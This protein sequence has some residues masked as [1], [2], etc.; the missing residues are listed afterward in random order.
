MTT[1]SE[2]VDAAPET[3]SAVLS[4]ALTCIATSNPDR[5]AVES[6]GGDLSYAEL[7]TRVRTMARGLASVGVGPGT[8]VG[9]YMRRSPA[10]LVALAGVAHSG[11]AY[12]PLDPAYPA[13][14]LAFMMEQAGASL[15]LVDAEGG[16]RL[17]PTA[18][19]LTVD[20]YGGADF[21]VFPS[22]A[23][24][25]TDTAYI[26]YTSGSSGQ[27]KGITTTSANFL[28]FA[29]GFIAT[30]GLNRDDVFLASTSISFDPHTVEI[31]LPILLGARIILLGDGEAR[32]PDV[33]ER[34][35]G[36][37][38]VTVVQGTP[39]FW[40]MMMDSGCRGLSGVT[41]LCGGEPLT[42]SLQDRLFDAGLT[43]LWNIYG[44]TETTV[45]CSAA[46]MV[47]GEQPTVGGPLPDTVFHLLDDTF[48]EIEVGEVGEL[49]IGG[50][51]LMAGYVN[52]PDLTAE[53]ILHAAP[54]GINDRLYRS[55]DMFEKR[56]G[57][58]LRYVGR[59]DSQVKLR[60]YRI[61]LLEIE[62]MLENH[63]QIGRAA[64]VVDPINKRL[65]AYIQLRGA[66]SLGSDEAA[67]FLREQLP[68]F[69]VPDR[70]E[71]VQRFPQTPSG[72]VDRIELA[73]RA[74]EAAQR[75]PIGGTGSSWDRISFIWSDV[76]GAEQI[77]P[78]TDF[79]EAG[80]NSVNMA[81]LRMR[82]QESFGVR[83]T[84]EQIHANRRIADMLRLIEAAPP[85]ASPASKTTLVGE[86][87]LSPSQLLLIEELGPDEIARDNLEILL[88]VD[89]GVD[90]T[91]QVVRRLCTAHDIFS[92]RSIDLRTRKQSFSRS[93]AYRI[94]AHE[95][96]FASLEEFLRLVP[97]LRE[98][99]GWSRPDLYR[100]E[101]FRTPTDSFVF[102]AGSH[103]LFD[104]ASLTLMMEN[105]DAM[106]RD[107]DYI[108]YD[109]HYSQWLQEASTLCPREA[110]P[111]AISFDALGTWPSFAETIAL[112]HRVVAAG[113]TVNRKHLPGRT[114]ALR[115]L[116]LAA[117]CLAVA[118]Q[119]ALGTI[120]CR[121]ASSGRGLL[122]GVDDLGTIGWLSHHFPL[123]VACKGELE[124]IASI[125]SHSLDTLAR[126]G[127]DY[128]WARYAARQPELMARPDLRHFP[129]YF[130]FLPD[131]GSKLAHI[132]DITD[133]LP[134]VSEPRDR[135]C[136]IGFVV[137]DGAELSIAAYYDQATL[138]TETVGRV[139]AAIS[140]LLTRHTPVADCA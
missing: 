69:M 71:I 96:T 99:V 51:G 135:L 44:P 30:L 120:P 119:F 57:G 139:L 73:N 105:L 17:S 49:L 41:G 19:V 65:V 1:F 50:P 2:P 18:P 32:N 60:G 86:V 74:G 23:S 10:M 102:F 38:G 103:L 93:G 108:S 31:I 134:E 66:A 79:F 97:K 126:D 115:D 132:A 111:W 53:R 106:L 101:V 89:V 59:S 131:V 26:I 125:I 136:G 70:I 107:P 11:A 75:T 95:H 129:V 76:L 40:Q 80:G 122:P 94:R 84:T 12:L 114:R 113:V 24:H 52:A 123:F 124:A 37:A 87:P 140:D 100:F 138:R 83:L 35:I 110:A 43:T 4:R 20:E 128:G 67:R 16:H 91:A 88:R 92:T 98:T 45:W 127:M 33:I 72:K 15:I 9:I 8:V 58:R 117:C 137:R 6:R 61:E 63:H 46:R 21:S 56:D 3:L 90:A 25:N 68:P 42:R 82:L 118:R 104:A 85:A 81:R 77:T 55:G 116:V 27:P 34:T 13:S 29:R 133:A 5:I 130:N 54:G 64:A 22:S 7:D 121:I 28:H 112:P 48:R 47:R 14:R 36:E 109:L 62:A 78:D 39:S